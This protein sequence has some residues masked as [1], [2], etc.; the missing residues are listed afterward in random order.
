MPV[1]SASPRRQHRRHALLSA[2]LLLGAGCR[3]AASDPGAEAAIAALTGLP[4]AVQF[5]TAA[6]P[7]DVSLAEPDQPLDLVTAARRALA[8]DAGLQ[9][10]LARVRIAL[11]QADQARLLPN[12]VLDVWVTWGGGSPWIQGAIQQNLLQALTVGRRSSAA[13][14]RL[15]KAAAE[16]ASAAL[17]LLADTQ[18]TFAAALAAD[19]LVPMLTERRELLD[20]L[21]A[22]TRLRATAGEVADVDVLTLE[23][24]RLGIQLELDAAQ[25]EQRMQRLHL[26]KLC[27]TPSAAADMPLVATPLPSAIARPA[28]T[29]IEL[30]LRHRPEIWAARAELGALGDDLAAASWEPWLD[31][32][33][34]PAEQKQ[35]PTTFGPAV[36]APLPVFDTGAARRRQLTAAQ[37]EAR[38]LLLAA[39][40]QVVEE[41][42]A[43]VAELESLVQSAG[44]IERELLP[45]L[46]TRRDRA[47]LAY[48]AGQ[49]DLVPLLLA[50]DDLREAATRA[51]QVQRDASAA[52][53]RL[54]RAMGGPAV[55]EGR[56]PD[57]PLA[58][59]S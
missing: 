6:G 54:Q 57:S 34:G 38:H 17:D 26:A 18:R 14:Q 39:Q 36:T 52:Q 43:A 42:R 30:A 45:R 16:A 22:V 11:A 48:R 58:R 31:V 29:C 28:A 50:E 5:R 37:Q 55:A 32:D 51:L 3:S 53:F 20:R 41:V 49:T 44:T 46:R 10:A 33:L 7:L 56:E 9:A 19:A 13:D 12:P 40:R 15:R 24:Q 25:R 35:G 4:D 47:E 1:P 59:Q 27:G 2:A 21:L 23:A 8:T